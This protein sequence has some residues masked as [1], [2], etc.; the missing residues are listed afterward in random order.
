MNVS[1]CNKYQCLAVFT[2]NVSVCF[3][4]QSLQWVFML[5]NEWQYL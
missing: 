5:Y 1:I 4:Y 3:K 2:M